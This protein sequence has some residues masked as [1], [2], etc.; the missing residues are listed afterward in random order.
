M[1]NFWAFEVGAEEFFVGADGLFVRAGAE[2]SG[3]AIVGFCRGV[4][5]FLVRTHKKKDVLQYSL[6]RVT[7]HQI[8]SD[9]IISSL[10]VAATL[11]GSLRPPDPAI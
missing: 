1:S 5:K 2:D 4:L 11:I 9:L 6:G 8:R 10:N 3:V 7:P